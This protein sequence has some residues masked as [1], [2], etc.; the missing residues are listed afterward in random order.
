MR[1]LLH[2]QVGPELK[3]EMPGGGMVMARPGAQITMLK[4][5]IHV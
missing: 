4:H 1:A 5:L 3:P 2:S